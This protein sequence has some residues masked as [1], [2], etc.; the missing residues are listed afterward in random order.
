M[1]Y[2]DIII[3]ISIII[4]TYI[5]GSIPFGLLIAKTKNVDLTKEGSKNIGA[6]NCG[7]VLG[8][9]YAVL[10]FALD[11]IKGALLV[12]LFRFEIIPNK[13]MLLSPALY[14]VIAVIGHSFSIFLKFKGG[15]GVATGSG[16]LFAYLPI[17]SIFSIVMFYIVIKKT[18]IAALGSLISGFFSTIIIIIFA[19]LG[20]DYVLNIPIDYHII[21]SSIIMYLLILYRHIPNIRRL[22][23]K[24]ELLIK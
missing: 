15:K 2:Y 24:N 19:I 22:I 13:Y 17:L 14:G 6:A 16:V 20:K 23:N 4:L 10:T 18:K 11:M 7:R 3:M 5:I 12:V 21:Y 9:K 1:K 8:T